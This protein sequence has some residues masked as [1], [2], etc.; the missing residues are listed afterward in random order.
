MK[1]QAK[2][3]L[4]LSMALA[5]LGT[6]LKALADEAAAE[7]RRFSVMAV[8]GEE[9]YVTKGSTKEIAAAPGV[10]LGQGS[11]VRTGFGTSLYFEADGDKTI[12]LDSNSQV[13]IT[14]SSSKKLKL[15]LKS[16]QLFFNVD[17]PL[18]AGEEMNIDAAQT[19]MSIRGTS[20]V[21]GYQENGLIFHLIEG[22]V[23][24][25]IGTQT[26]SLGAGERAT[27]VLGTDQ[28]L[29]TNQNS[30]Y[31]LRGV[32]AFNW[33]DLDALGLEAVLEQRD[34]L[35]L[36]AI[37]LTGEEEFAQAQERLQELKS[38]KAAREEALRQEQERQQSALD[39]SSGANS[40]RID[41]REPERAGGDGN[42]DGNSGW[43]TE[44][45]TGGSGSTDE[46]SSST[47]TSGS[48]DETSS[49]TDT[50]GSTGSTGGG[51]TSSS[52][53]YS[54]EPSIQGA[55]NVL[56]DTP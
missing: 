38:E 34:R 19:S 32:E 29:A 36:S 17:K 1:I 54:T 50:S 47:D 14:K 8:N 25:N 26:I 42:D 6:N 18:S 43:M 16:G 3:L 11:K 12:K 39:S 10:P 21:L 7:S 56:I 30:I 49:N 51:E 22:H 9:A 55:A 53:T 4:V 48:T 35:D 27:L 15:T 31:H 28:K 23:D 20:G 5:L 41:G 37:G 44:T 45:M 52:D 46:T 2:K 40:A 24:W 13:E 33:R